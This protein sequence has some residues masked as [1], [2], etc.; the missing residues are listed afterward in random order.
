M[1][2]MYVSARKI[3]RVHTRY[4]PEAID[5]NDYRQIPDKYLTPDREG[6]YPEPSGPES[7]KTGCLT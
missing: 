6:G 3:R 4:A 2:F 7:D 1:Y 5:A